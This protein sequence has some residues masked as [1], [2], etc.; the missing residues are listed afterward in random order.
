AGHFSVRLQLKSLAN[1]PLVRTTL[2]LCGI[3]KTIDVTRTIYVTLDYELSW[4]HLKDDRPHLLSITTETQEGASLTETMEVRRFA[5]SAH[6]V[7][8]RLR[9]VG[10]PVECAK[11]FY[12]PFCWVPCHSSADYS[13]DSEGLQRC[14]RPGGC[15]SSSTSTDAPDDDG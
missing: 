6:T 7:E 11:H 8:G 3:E 10:D 12:G 9:I 2:S 5:R 4:E 15:I 13:C 1:P 14:V